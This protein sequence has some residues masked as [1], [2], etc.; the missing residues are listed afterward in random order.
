MRQSKV[1]NNYFVSQYKASTTL[2]E[3]A[4][5]RSIDFEPLT[6]NQ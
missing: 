1:P 4:L 3:S 2:H 5:D 6:F